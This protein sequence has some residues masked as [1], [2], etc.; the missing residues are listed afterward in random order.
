MALVALLKTG[1]RL[2]RSVNL[3]PSSVALS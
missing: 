2:P 3:L 1:E